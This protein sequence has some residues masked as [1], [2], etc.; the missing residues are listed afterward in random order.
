MRNSEKI[1]IPIIVIMFITV[2][3]C[4]LLINEY[5]ENKSIQIKKGN[6]SEDKNAGE[7]LVKDEDLKCENTAILIGVDKEKGML[8]FKALDGVSVIKLGYDSKTQILGKHD[9]TILLDQ[10]P[11]GEVLDLTYSLRTNLLDKLKISQNAWTQTGVSKFS[12]NPKTRIMEIADRMYRMED[13]V[14]VSYG[15][16]LAELI[17]VTSVDTLIVKGVDKKVCSI[18][19]EKGHG[20]VR[21]ANDAY[22][23]G[24]WLEVGQEIIKPISER[25]LLPVPEGEYKVRITNRGYAGEENIV[26]RRDKETVVDLSQIKIEEVAIGHVAF[27]IE[28]DYAQLSI[29]GEMTD[30]EERVPL[31]FGIHSIHV[32]LAGYESVDTKIKVASEFA[33]VDI[34]LDKSDDESESSSSSTEYHMG[35]SSSERS[36]TKSSSSSSAI[37]STTAR[38]SSSSSSSS[39]KKN[40]SS[41][42]SSLSSNTGGYTGGNGTT[43]GSIPESSSSSS[44][45]GLT[46]TT[47]SSSS[48]SSSDFSDDDIIATG[49][50]IEISSPAGATLYV[51]GEYK[52]TLPL[53]IDKVT[54]THIFTLAMEGHVTKSYTEYIDDDGNSPTYSYPAL[55]A[56]EQEQQEVKEE[57]EEQLRTMFDFEYSEEGLVYEDPNKAAYDEQVKKGYDEMMQTPFAELIESQADEERERIEQYLEQ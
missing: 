45:T 51:D 7:E 14:T 13:T 38:K 37:V 42:S 27:N 50:T 15:T 16:K 12:I 54:G 35:E 11:L 21:L 32:E 5:S 10:I 57:V 24:G 56:E 2:F 48:S 23:I 52:G 31:E 8:E 47:S 43:G 41:S 1:I 20:Y 33:D 4:Y 36:R 34:T 30:F 53:K 44:A 29:D 28:P 22:F 17:D 55:V 19:V 25:M 39:G 26:I 40:R 46:D 49:E 9:N 6:V 18:I 3:G